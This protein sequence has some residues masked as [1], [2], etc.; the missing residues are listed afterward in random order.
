MED[1]HPHTVFRVIERYAADNIAATPISYKSAFALI[2]YPQH[3]DATSPQER[4][5]FWNQLLP[6]PSP[7]VNPL[8]GEPGSA[9]GKDIVGCLLYCLFFAFTILPTAL[10][11][12]SGLHLALPTAGS[13]AQSNPDFKI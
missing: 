9:L 10:F 5:Q 2:L 6:F 4:K 13:Q 11:I 1:L 12:S 3:L 7:S 8:T